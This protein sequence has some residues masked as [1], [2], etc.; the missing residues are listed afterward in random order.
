MTG[1]LAPTA[2]RTLWTRMAEIYGHKFTSA[3]G[4]SESH[5]AKTWAKGL[6]GIGPQQLANGLEACLVSADPWP[7]TLPEFRARCL[8][9]PSL[10]A[11]KLDLRNSRK[12]A[13]F[14]HLVWSFVDHTAY[15][16][17][18]GDKSDRML[19]DAYELAREHVMRGGD[20]PSAIAGEIEQERW[21]YRTPPPEH[22]HAVLAR[23][24]VEVQGA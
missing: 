1:P 21:V 20:M 18:H 9:V 10:A 3:F 7:P 16:N 4:D 2:M 13:L 12:R 15:G 19:R 22:R 14:T 6:T 8:S 24:R 5:A 11:V 23:A 17:A